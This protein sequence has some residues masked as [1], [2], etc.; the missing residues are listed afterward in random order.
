M[1]T[2]D[3]PLYEQLYEFMVKEIM[4]GSLKNGEKVPSKRVLAS[5]LKVSQNTVETAYELLVAEGYLRA[6]ARSGFYVCTRDQSSWPIK[7]DVVFPESEEETRTDVL[8]Y[9]YNFGTNIV[10]TNFFP[11]LYLD[12]NSQRHNLI[13]QGP[14]KSWPSTG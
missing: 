6:V 11:V 1:F 12:Q 2:H 10:D 7:N 4:N 5:H 14:S 13:Q 8:D 9:R 3:K